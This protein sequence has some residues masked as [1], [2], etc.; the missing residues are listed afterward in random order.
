MKST[1]ESLTFIIGFFVCVVVFQ[2]FL[3]DKATEYMLIL[4]LLGM[5]LLN[6]NDEKIVAK[7]ESLVK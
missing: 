4:V 2:T 3:G 6:G 1:Y 5:L 7:L